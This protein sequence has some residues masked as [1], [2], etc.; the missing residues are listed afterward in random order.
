MEWENKV[1]SRCH[2]YGAPG[3]RV[4]TYLF[5]ILEDPCWAGPEVIRNA[6]RKIEDEYHTK[7]KRRR[8]KAIK[9]WRFELS[10][11]AIAGTREAF[12]F[13]QTDRSAY[14][15]RGGPKRYPASSTGQRK[16]VGRALAAPGWENVPAG[17][18]VRGRA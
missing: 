15:R 3:C 4:K 17:K 2:R 9:E 10:A 18:G 11:K 14:L 12:N 1:E 16:T 6:V 13:L 8:S 5:D 7:R